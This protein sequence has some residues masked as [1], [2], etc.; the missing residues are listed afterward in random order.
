MR[1]LSCNIRCCV[2]ED[3]PNNWI[4]RRD[5]CAEVIRS[6]SPEVICFQEMWEPQYIDLRAAFPDYRSYSVIDEPAGRHPVNTIF[7]RADAYRLISAGGYWLSESP[8]V[9]GSSSWGS[10]YIR[11]ANWVRL[12]HRL[13]RYEVRVVNTH[14]DNVSQAAR[15]NQA[16]L[17]CEDA[18]SYPVD[19][20]QVLTGD[21]NCDAS[22]AAIGTLRAGGWSDTY[23]HIHGTESPGHTYHEFL[24]PG[25]QSDVNK[26]DWI[27]TRGEAEVATAGII[28]DSV[29][30][31]YPSDHYFI[32]ADMV[33]SGHNDVAGQPEESPGGE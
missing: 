11:L 22:N 10:A 32:S 27:F 14:L 23:S 4:H 28:R 30:G 2:A 7:Y 31:R 25:F 20:P 9:A 6:R 33:I 5:L 21:M 24:G 16:R 13:A 12:T 1:V 19:Y 26:M 17:L 15:E 29:D 18:A 8:H 3:G